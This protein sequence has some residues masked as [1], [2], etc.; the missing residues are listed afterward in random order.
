MKA[1]VFSITLCFL[2]I[3]AAS[4]AL[5]KE[6]ILRE[7]V[8][9]QTDKQ[10]YLAGELI[11]M[12][13]L[14]TNQDGTPIDLSKVV[15][16]ELLDESNPVLQVKLEVANGIG[17]GWMMIPP[18][19]ASGSYRMLAY[20]RYMKNEGEEVFFSRAIPILNTFTDSSHN[21]E[22]VSKPDEPFTVA[23]AYTPN[24][25]NA[26][27]SGNGENE[28]IRSLQ[29]TPD[30]AAYPVRTAGSISLENIPEDIYTLSLSIYKN[31]V[32][33]SG[34]SFR[35]R[36]WKNELQ[37]IE[38]VQPFTSMYIP[39]YEGHILEG[40]MIDFQTGLQVKK[41]DVMPFLSFPGDKIR[42]FS[43]ALGK[44]GN[45]VFN[46]KRISGVEEVATAVVTF[47]D[48]RFRI[49]IESPFALHTSKPLPVLT[50]N[51]VH[52][53]K[54]RE[55][56]IGLQALHMYMS[57]SIS[58][59][60]YESAL[61]QWS[62]SIEYLLD[63]YIRFP[64]MREV[65]AEFIPQAR[66]RRINDRRYLNVFTGGIGGAFSNANSLV[67]LDGIPI[68]DHEN[69]YSYDPSLV[70][71]IGIYQNK[72]FFGGRL[73]FN[74]IVSFKTHNRD[75]HGLQVDEATQVFSY[76]GTQK[77]RCFYV[78]SYNTE[79]ERKSRIPDFRHTLLWNP[80]VYTDGK[81]SVAIPF[82]TSDL[83]GDFIVKVEGITNDGRVVYAEAG[84]KVE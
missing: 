8:Y 1:N 56:S 27:A 6:K 31:D 18:T 67:L 72:Y 58:E 52:K 26:K 15:Y 9:L 75:Y 65:F 57:D 32:S 82:T 74:G 33:L 16:V 73:L 38:N 84:L 35:L 78:P 11:W 23:I 20:T 14:T 53:D 48:D 44:N 80:E 83:T 76:E 66:F 5:D 55:R 46:T 64:T 62:P 4:F 21:M 42:L 63:D 7:R 41:D 70:E 60:E 2:L 17:S 61:F 37:P 22:V 69:I 24:E 29:L 50:V 49:D 77:K 54:L 47:N 25:R 19:L 40:K 30:K 59:Y 34:S 71:R 39:E 3:S 43:G 45:V 51:I 12:K 28:I 79:A 36:E 81:T 13:V 68:L 10:V